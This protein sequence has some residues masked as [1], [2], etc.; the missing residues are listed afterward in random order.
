MAKAKNWAK[1]VVEFRIPL[2]GNHTDDNSVLKSLEDAMEDFSKKIPT[3][4]SRVGIERAMKNGSTIT[5][6]EWSG[7]EASA[8]IKWEVVK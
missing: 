6:N 2:V 8:T 3:T 4:C 7:G 1:V 5:S